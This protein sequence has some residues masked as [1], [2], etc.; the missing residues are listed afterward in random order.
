MKKCPFCAEEI[1]DEA[2]VCK[3]CKRELIGEEHP[4]VSST[5]AK[6]DKIGCGTVLLIII[7]AGAVLSL[8]WL[9]NYVL[10]RL[11]GENPSAVIEKPISQ[12]EYLKKSIPLDYRNGLYE[13]YKEG[14]LFWVRGQVFQLF[15]N[16]NGA[17]INTKNSVLGYLEN[18]VFVSYK[19]MPPILMGDIV[20]V[21]GRYAGTQE[22]KNIVGSVFKEPTLKGE[23]TA[24]QEESGKWETVGTGW[25]K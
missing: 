17:T 18:P 12:E 7:L 13:K 21:W 8:V 22:L 24:K 2:I 15:P 1:Q 16:E 19:E 14:D 11:K 20:T 4:A 5:N 3:H 23:Y 9:T 25:N 6:K 10:D